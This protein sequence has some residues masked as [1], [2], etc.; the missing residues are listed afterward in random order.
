MDVPCVIQLGGFQLQFAATGG[1]KKILHIVDAIHEQTIQNQ[2]I[3]AMLFGTPED[4]APTQHVPLGL[5][6][7]QETC[8]A[9][10]QSPLTACTH[11]PSPL[12]CPH[13]QHHPS[14]HSPTY[15]PHLL[16]SFPCT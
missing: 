6:S 3:S 14:L 15:T 9:P 4:Q 2:P 7:P 11:M 8:T 1:N 5:S 10:T 13:R 12:T 16:P